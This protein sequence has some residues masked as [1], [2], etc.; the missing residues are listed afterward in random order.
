M[1]MPAKENA[2]MQS[3]TNNEQSFGMQ[4]TAES[5]KILSSTI[6]SHK[7]EAVVRELYC[8]AVDSHIQAGTERPVR[9]HLP[10]TFEQFF[11]VEDFG[12]GLSD[13][14]VHEIFTVYFSS[15]KKEDNTQIGA[16]GLGSKS[17][18]AYQDHMIIRSRYNGIER[19][20]IAFINNSGMPTIK[21]TSDDVHTKEPN[22]VM[23]R[24]PVNQ[25]DV[26]EFTDRAEKVFSFFKNRPDVNVE[27]NYDLSQEQVDELYD[28]GYLV[29]KNES[30][31][32]YRGY[33]NNFIAVM[34]GV[35][36]QA[37]FD[38]RYCRN[39]VLLNEME[40]NVFGEE[41][42]YYNFDHDQVD[43]ASSINQDT[44]VI[45]NYD[46]GE[47]AFNAGREE[48]SYEGDTKLNLHKKFVGS[49][50]EYVER[51][52]K[53]IDQQDNI[54]H[55]VMK[56]REYFAA[57]L[58]NRTDVFK[59][60]GDSI[61]N[62][63][64]K[65]AYNFTDRHVT[66]YKSHRSSGRVKTANYNK[67]YY[68]DLIDK[69][70][71][72]KEE[73]LLFVYANDT[74]EISGAVKS[75]R[76]VA[77]ERTGKMVFLDRTAK[78]KMVDLIG[79]LNQIHVSELKQLAESID[80]DAFKRKSSTRHSVEDTEFRAKDFASL[81]DNRLQTFDVN[82]I[83]LESS[84]Y[85]SK[86]KVNSYVQ[87]TGHDGKVQ[88]VEKFFM[89]M[90]RLQMD[91]DHVFLATTQNKKK[92]QKLGVMSLEEFIVK[93][94]HKFKDKIQD[95]HNRSA[96]SIR[97]SYNDKFYE[98]SQEIVFSSCR[99]LAEFVAENTKEG[100]RIRDEINK[101]KLDVEQTSNAF[102]A[103]TNKMIQH[104]LSESEWKA[105]EPNDNFLNLMEQFEK[106]VMEDFLVEYPLAKS[107]DFDSSVDMEHLSLYIEAVDGAQ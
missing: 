90:L 31:M 64:G 75:A 1:K 85:V 19:H 100:K 33:F 73:P 93:N 44:C 104:V 52:Q 67:M 69:L 27:L 71:N 79:A 23:I 34:G 102:T 91:F 88:S 105:V 80:P 40:H 6:Y 18:F 42:E 39:P 20:Y 21:T 2:V 78:G 28:K 103:Y 7:I 24:V 51:V 83:D 84:V 9:V 10:T 76:I 99:G 22:G 65:C 92:M 8:N 46:L 101:E 37:E 50:M 107:V 97:G 43:V 55:A 45:I 59:F 94:A 58:I 87:L 26:S 30:S 29:L 15:T 89:T 77:G 61:R 63:M 74:K 47:I 57:S 32:R 4:A 95:G 3:D 13:K 49:M 11:E 38:R 14:D 53:E 81:N 35:S 16:L 5:F 17:P 56:L 12:L 48:I 68:N 96:H 70:S 66:M 36:Y 41:A 106:L 86:S 98:M 72:N 62:H 60:D 25:S 54:A 82:N